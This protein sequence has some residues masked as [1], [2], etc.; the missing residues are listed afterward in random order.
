MSTL[1]ESRAGGGPRTGELELGLGIPGVLLGWIADWIL[2]SISRRK[3]GRELSDASIVIKYT[4][5]EWWTNIIHQ[6]SILDSMEGG[7][8]RVRYALTP[9]GRRT[10][11]NYLVGINQVPGWEDAEMRLTLH[12]S[13]KNCQY[14]DEL[15]GKKRTE[16]ASAVR[17][18][19]DQ[20]MVTSPL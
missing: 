12:A 7:M 4:F 20:R 18:A 15:R 2:G 13:T 9:V 17:R 3:T 1:E 11:N 6:F 5:L 8:P 10:Y 19:K 16:A 14:T